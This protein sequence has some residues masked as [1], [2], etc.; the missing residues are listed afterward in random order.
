MAS[1]TGIAPI[2]AHKDIKTIELNTLSWTSD[3]ALES[4]NA[5]HL[6]VEQQ[7]QSAIDWYYRKK[8]TKAL[9]SR[10]L[11]LTAII[12]ATIGG[13]IPLVIS[14]PIVNKE[15]ALEKWGYAVFGA[16][17]GCIALDKFFGFSTG[18]VRY[19]STAQSIQNELYK[20]QLDW[21][22][23]MSRLAGAVP[24]SAQ[25]EE[26]LQLAKDFSSRVMQEVTQE[27]Q[28]W[29]VEFQSSLADL[30]KTTKAQAEA[31]RPGSLTLTLDN[32]SLSDQPVAVNIDGV[33]HGTMTGTNWAIR[34][35]APGP[36]AVVVTG[37]QNGKLLQQSGV[38]LI[39]A[40]GAAKLDLHFSA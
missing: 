19:I 16:A 11:R 7:A 13:L 29:I 28:Q 14:L 1:T 9:A 30:E 12:L 6:Y 3:H 8:R 21:A 36:H 25:I 17:A 34:Q 32:A 10:W 40:G 27:T 37:R 2:A 4:L 23:A 38:V 39:P 18:W 35:I 15:W 22:R 33:D 24:N 20:F 26:F 31:A 5:V